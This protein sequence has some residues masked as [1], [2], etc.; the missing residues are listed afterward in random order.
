MINKA[1]NIQDLEVI[2]GKSPNGKLPQAVGDGIF[3]GPGVNDGIFTLGIKPMKQEGIFF[4][5]YATTN[6]ELQKPDDQWVLQRRPGRPLYPGSTAHGIVLT[7]PSM[8]EDEPQKSE[9]WNNLRLALGV[10][11]GAAF[12]YWLASRE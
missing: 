7:G 3:G 5:P 12:V 2:G 4:D 9:M 6:Y 8:G 10:G 11:L 1:K